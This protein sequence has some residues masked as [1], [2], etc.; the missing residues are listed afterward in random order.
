MSEANIKIEGMNCQ[1][2]VMRVRK[3]LE[4]LSGVE[5]LGVDIGE[6]RVRFDASKTS[7]SDI[8]SAISKA[9]YKVVK[10]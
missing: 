8:E 1:H 7:L 2:C 9:G 10:S 6:A 3:A 5:I 4:A